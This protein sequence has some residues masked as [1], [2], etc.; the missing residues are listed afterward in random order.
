[1]VQFYFLS[2]FLN[3]VA[4]LSLFFSSSPQRKGPSEGL[5][6]FLR[7]S[8]V[9]L[10]LGILCAVTGAFKLLTVIRGDIPIVGDF[11]PAAAGIIVGS[12]LLLE[13]YR[14]PASPHRVP[15]RS[16]RKSQAE[17]GAK[18]EEGAGAPQGALEPSPNR[19][20]AFLLDNR[21]AVGLAGM[22]AGVVHFLF[23]MVLFL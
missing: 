19:L 6:L 12:T 13:R 2:V 3:L 9:S 23:P 17:S 20:E 8:T 21:S 11:L 22:I 5:K 14:D 7:D 16:E 15:S 4:G 1:M 18:A 10:V